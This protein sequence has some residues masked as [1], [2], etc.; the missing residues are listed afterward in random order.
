M[1]KQQGQGHSTGD[2]IQY[3]I[4]TYSG[5]ESGKEYI[6]IYLN[7]FIVHPRLTELCTSTILQYKKKQYC[8][9]QLHNIN[10]LK[11]K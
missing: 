5:K 7:H 1:D 2:Y 3:L 4:I 10:L 8:K 6:Y 11:E 9:V